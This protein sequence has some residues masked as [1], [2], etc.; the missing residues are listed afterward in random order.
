MTVRNDTNDSITLP[1]FGYFLAVDDKGGS[2]KADP[3]GSN[4]PTTFPPSK[5]VSGSADLEVP[6][7]NDRSTLSVSFSTIFGSLDLNSISVDGIRI[8]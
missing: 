5:T 2:Y 7:P 1:L 6:I 3:H 4:W 8:Q